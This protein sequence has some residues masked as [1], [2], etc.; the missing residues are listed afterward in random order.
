M[1]DTIY[2]Y[3]ENCVMA[4]KQVPAREL[5]R[6]DDPADGGDWSGYEATEQEAAAMEARGRFGAR[7]AATIREYLRP[8]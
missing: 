4:G 8:Y 1:A 6:Y 2:I 3:N 5:D 7:V